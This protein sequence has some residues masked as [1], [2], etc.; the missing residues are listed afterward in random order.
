MDT[1]GGK[2]HV[3]TP[4]FPKLNSSTY[5][6]AFAEAHAYVT[7]ESYV[8]G[9]REF[10][11]VETGQQRLGVSVVIPLA[12]YRRVGRAPILVGYNVLILDI[13][14]NRFRHTA[15]GVS[16]VNAYNIRIYHYR[17]IV[18]GDGNNSVPMGVT[19]V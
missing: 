2:F 12:E 18:T 11:R 19:K 8:V 1:V 7:L 17:L 10:K 4:F 9:T 15:P 5:R 13:V 6:L 16:S 14:F 3:T